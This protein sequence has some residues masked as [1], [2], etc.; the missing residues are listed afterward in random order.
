[1]PPPSLAQIEQRLFRRLDL[2]GA[3]EFR[4]GAERIVDDSLADIDELAA[5]PGVMHRTAVL[6][7]VDDAD[8]G[9]EKLREIGGATDLIEHAGVFEFGLQHHRVCELTGLDPPGDCLI[10]A[11]MHRI[12]EMVGGEKFRDPLIRLVVGQQRAEQRLLRL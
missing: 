4:L 12:G 6:A 2:F 11:A 10:D 1:M 9:A 7:G 5:Q 3:V 8:H